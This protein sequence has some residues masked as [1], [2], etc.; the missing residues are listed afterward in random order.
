MSDRFRLTPT[1]VTY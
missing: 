1:S